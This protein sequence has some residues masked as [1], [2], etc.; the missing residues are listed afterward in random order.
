MPP[1]AMTMGHTNVHASGPLFM[2][3]VAQAVANMEELAA[4]ASDCG[5]IGIKPGSK[6]EKLT[7][8]A[9]VEVEAGTLMPESP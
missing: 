6:D 2:E 7:R 4:W 9:Y 5:Y 1:A 3:K 8:T